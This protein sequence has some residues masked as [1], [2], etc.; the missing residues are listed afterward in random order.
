[1][2]ITV[3]HKKGGVGKST[4]TTNLG[5]TL[6]CTILDLDGLSSSVL[7]NRLREHNGRESINCL[8]A[9]TVDSAKEIL[10]KYQQSSE[11]LI[12]DSGGYDDNINRLALVAANM[13]ITPLSPTQL[14]LFGLQDFEQILKKASAEFNTNIMSHILINRADVRSKSDVLGL[15]KFVAKRPETFKLLKTILHDRKDYERAYA[16]G[17]SVIEYN[18]NENAALEV[19]RLSKEIKQILT[20]E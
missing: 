14:D 8:T 3:A 16:V 7:F 15:Q 10:I 1:M 4:V 6:N 12:V 13:I 20:V 18:P 17:E 9:Q 5:I 11:L 2:I 19:I